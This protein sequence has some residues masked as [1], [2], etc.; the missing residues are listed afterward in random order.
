MALHACATC[1]TATLDRPSSVVPDAP[2][3]D[4]LLVPALAIASV[5]IYTHVPYTQ[6][7]DM[8]STEWTSWRYAP[9]PHIR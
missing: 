2:Q 3:N 9:L 4:L 5:Y 6:T 7:Y 8:Y 1:K